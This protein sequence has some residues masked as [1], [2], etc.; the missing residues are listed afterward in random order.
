MVD[1]LGL[2]VPIEVDEDADV[3][4]ADGGQ[5]AEE[6]NGGKLVDELDSDEDD[7]AED[8]EQDSAV[9]PVVVELGRRVHDVRTSDRHCLPD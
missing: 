5:D 3:D 1:L 8:Q 7:D 2:V 4:G 6:C 9:H